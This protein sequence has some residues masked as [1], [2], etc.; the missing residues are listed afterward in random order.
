MLNGHIDERAITWIGHSRGGEGITR[1]YDR[2]F[3]GTY[4]PTHFDI[5]DG[6]LSLYDVVATDLPSLN[7]LLAQVE[8]RID[9]VVFYFSPDRFDL[10]CEPEPHRWDD[11]VLMVRGPFPDDG[12]PFMAPP[13]A[14]H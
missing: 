11:G 3:D 6:V 12:P 2:L 14:R 5:D 10:E 8:S 9:R 13:P 7:E 1:A 4:T